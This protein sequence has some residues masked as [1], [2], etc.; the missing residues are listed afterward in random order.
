M[1]INSL[2]KIEELLDVATSL[3]N[4]EIRDGWVICRIHLCW[5]VFSLKNHPQLR[6]DVIYKVGMT[7]R[8]LELYVI[9]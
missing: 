5:Y 8:E 4:V 6:M 7:M 2:V 3:D 1:V 9:K